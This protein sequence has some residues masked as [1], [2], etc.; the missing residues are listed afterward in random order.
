MKQ[1]LLLLL[2]TGLFVG[3]SFAQVSVNT[4]GTTPNN[5]AMLDVKSTNKGLLIPWKSQ[6][7]AKD[8]YLRGCYHSTAMPLQVL[9]RV[10]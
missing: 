9:P 8:F 4:D 7:P 5:S 1:L 2:L 6:A 3:R 10:L